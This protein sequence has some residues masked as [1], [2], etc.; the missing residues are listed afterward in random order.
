MFLD[1][2]CKEKGDR[3]ERPE[4]KTKTLGCRTETERKRKGKQSKV[5][6][7]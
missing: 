1:L 4:V 5:T 3:R 6:S 7:Y 2:Y